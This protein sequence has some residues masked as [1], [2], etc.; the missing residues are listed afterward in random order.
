LDL[1]SLIHK[2]AAISDDE[3]LDAMLRDWAA[4][5]YGL[6]DDGAQLHTAM[7]LWR[8]K[9]VA[10]ALTQLCAIPPNDALAAARSVLLRH[11][12]RESAIR[13]IDEYARDAALRQAR[14]AGRPV[15]FDKLQHERE[16]AAR[17]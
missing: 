3:Q 5:C 10:N 13:L 14:E 17:A 6:C 12:R 15:G 2:L 1:T 9:R 7:E 11:P 16:K 8:A 4:D